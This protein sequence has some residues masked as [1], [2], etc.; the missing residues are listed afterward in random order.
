MQLRRVLL[1]VL[2][3]AVAGLLQMLVA[4]RLLLREH[5]RRLR[6]IHLSLVGAD[7]RLLYVELRLDVLDAGPRGPDLGLRLF[8][9]DA[10]V[11]LVDAGNHVP[12]GDMLVIG[13]RHGGEIAGH[14]RGERDL[15][16]RDEG[17][18]G[19]LKTLGM[20]EVEI[21]AAYGSGEKHGP[22]GGDDGG[23]AQE[24]AAALI[25]ARLR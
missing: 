16:R 25:A 18:V 13:D 11:A 1:G 6:L 7:L 8:E 23:S 21:A 20:V 9:R 2:N 22:D 15:P 19:G 10:I 5:Q 17:I 3:A 4:L 12:G 24:A 14:V